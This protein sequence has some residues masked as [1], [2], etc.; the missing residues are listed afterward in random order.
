MGV[1]RRE[2]EKKGGGME[3]GRDG[4]TEFVISAFSELAGCYCR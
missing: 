3:G 4:K 2:R 1:G